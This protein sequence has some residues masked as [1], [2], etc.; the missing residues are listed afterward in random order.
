MRRIRSRRIGYRLLVKHN[1][2]RTHFEMIKF[3]TCLAIMNY[4]MNTMQH[5]SAIVIIVAVSI[6]LHIK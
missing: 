2:D 6:L 4:V 3:S 1:Y 5:R